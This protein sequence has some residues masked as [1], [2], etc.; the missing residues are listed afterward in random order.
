MNTY[1]SLF[2]CPPEL[3]TERIDEV[4]EKVKRLIARQGGQ[5]T[6]EEKWG[7]RRLAYPIARHREG[8]YILVRFN[9]PSESVSAL[10]NMYRVTDTVIRSL[11][12]R[13]QDNRFIRIEKARKDQLAAKA[14]E[15][16]LKAESAAAAA[17]ATGAATATTTAP[18]APSP[19]E[20]P[21]ASGG[22]PVS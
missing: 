10:E 8:F 4:L 13:V 6:L 1:E 22:G 14:R 19:T 2:V 21:S 9:A 5:L 3:A 18:A 17:P 16:Q 15:A 20:P 11:T 7:K 12:I